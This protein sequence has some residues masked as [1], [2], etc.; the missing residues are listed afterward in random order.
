M[1]APTF[2]IITQFMN[3]GSLHDFLE[4]RKQKAEF[5][6]DWMMK[7]IARMVLRGLCYLHSKNVIHRD[8]K[9]A[10][11]LLHREHHAGPLSI[12]IAGIILLLSHQTKHSQFRSDFGVSRLESAPGTLTSAPGTVTCMQTHVFKLKLILFVD[13]LSTRGVHDATRASA[14]L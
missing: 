8:L 11:I 1:E 7:H 12:R 14:Q 10:N 9:P 4:E 5:M 13:R 3:M 2:M 6:P